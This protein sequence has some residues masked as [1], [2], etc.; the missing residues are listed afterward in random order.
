MSRSPVERLLLQ[1]GGL[2]DAR[3]R[4][5]PDFAAWCADHAG[6]RVE[7]LAG[8]ARMP[9]LRLPAELPL[10]GD[11]DVL[12][13][14]RLQFTHYFGAAAQ[15]WPLA[16]WPGGACALAEGDPAAL[17]AEAGR[18]R[19]RLLSLRP[20]WTQAPAAD[21]E[22]LVLDDGMLTRVVHHDG[23]LAELEQRRCDDG[24]LAELDG[25]RLLQATD[26][27]AGPPGQAGPD[28]IARPT[29][30]RPL[31]WAWAASA[32]AACVLVAVQA[33]GVRQ[34]AERLSEQAAVLDRLQR[35]TRPAAATP[36][37]APAIAVRTRAGSA[38]RLL[39]ADWASRWTEVERALPPGLQLAALDL[40]L[41]RRSLRLEGRAANPDTV[42]RLVDR[43]GQQAA[44][45]DEVVLTRLQQSDTPAEGDSL[46]FEV[47]RQRGGGR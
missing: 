9:C 43:L 42:T 15:A 27:L 14:A 39:D 24:L 10:H 3:G 2:R 30:L 38:A 47:V 6:A 26:L 18:H 41:D 35:A 29:A 28:F 19:V 25:T 12:G 11:D 13:Y 1:A 23:R 31:V 40:D 17:L 37:S 32:A 33:V 20:S 8:P 7:L 36:A 46:R 22:T 16:T 21:G 5:W 45:G 44:P 4:T 34:D